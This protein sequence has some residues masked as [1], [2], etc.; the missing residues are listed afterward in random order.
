MK[1]IKIA[2]QN[3]SIHKFNTV[4]VG[5]GAAGMNCAKK[6][7]EYMDQKGVANPHE[8]IAVVTAG[9]PLGASRMSGSDKQT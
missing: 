3:V 9:L 7:Y 2:D 8:R 4:V 5:S 6:L 1:N